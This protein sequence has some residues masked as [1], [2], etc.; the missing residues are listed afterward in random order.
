MKRWLAVCLI[1]ATPL[2]AEAHAYLV[3]SD[4]PHK[5]SLSAAPTRLKLRFSEPI[6]IAFMKLVLQRDGQIQKAPLKISPG[7]DKR[8][9]IVESAF[10]DA[11]SYQLGWSIV[12][13]DGH[14]TEGSVIFSVNAR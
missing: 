3:S 11:G 5:A 13:R 9:V 1:A 8:M 10:A 4:P 7:S 6:E 2:L 14:R 12:A